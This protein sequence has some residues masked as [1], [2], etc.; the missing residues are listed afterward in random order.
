MASHG[1]DLQQETHSDHGGDSGGSTK[2]QFPDRESP[3][4]QQ[5]PGEPQ[6]K[7]QTRVHQQP[8][9]R[10]ASRRGANALPD[11]GGVGLT[12]DQA[13]NQLQ[14]TTSG[15]V[16]NT[17]GQVVNAGATGAVRGKGGKSDN[18]LRLRLD[19]NLELDV[20]LELQARIHGDITL[21]LL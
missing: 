5:A 19:L 4:Q 13:G 1:E 11:A 10:G 17:E 15:A 2:E 18:P 9:N 3:V 6:A 7:R 8:R 16:Q 21:A 12:D 14:R 20:Q